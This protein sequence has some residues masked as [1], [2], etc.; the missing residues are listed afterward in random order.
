MY[1]KNIL[2]AIQI[3]IDN[4]ISKAGFDKTVQGII[5]KCVDEKNG[6]YVVIYQ[7]SSFYAYSNDTSQT[8]SA[9]TPVYVHIPKN[10]FTKTKTIIGSVNK[11]GSDYINKVDSI[12]KYDII[13]N[14]VLT[15]DEEQGVCSYLPSGDILILYNKDAESSL[16]DIDA[17]AANTYINQANYLVF[18]GK[19]RTNLEKEQKY[20][21]VYG[22]GFDLIF[23]DNMT[24]ESVKRTYLVSVN[25]MTGNPYEYTKA[26]NQK[27]VFNIDGAN[28]IEI[29]KIY[30]FCYDFP[31]SS[32]E[33]KPDD[34]FVSDITLEAAA[35][36]TNDELEGNKLT[37]KTPQGVYFDDTDNDNSQRS[38]NTEVRIENNLVNENS[39][40]LKYYW[41]KENYL[42]NTASLKYQRYGGIGWECLNDYN[43]IEQDNGT[44][45]KLSWIANKSKYFVSKGNVSS[46]TTEYKCVVIYN[47]TIVLT[48]QITIYNYSS[49]Y[50]IS[51][52]SDSGVNFSYDNGHPTLTCVV[53]TPGDYIYSWGLIDT[54][55]TYSDIQQTTQD[56]TTYHTYLNRYNELQTGLRNGTI[57]LTTEIQQELIQLRNSLENYNKTIMRVEDNVIYNLKLNMISNF[58]TFVCS[59]YRETTGGDVVYLGKGKIK[60]TNDLNT[61]DNSYT[62][63]INHGNQIFKYD[64]DGKSPASKFLENP[65][66]I[67]PFSFTLYDEKG[68]EINNDAID[69]KNV[70]WTV[71]TNNTMINVSA[72]HGNPTSIDEINQTKTYTEYKELFFEIPS[73]YNSNNIRNTVQLEIKYKNKIVRGNAEPV[74]LKEG[75]AGSNGTGLVCR[76]IPNLASG[77]ALAT[78]PIVTHNT[79]LP[80]SSSNP[81]LNYEPAN[82]NVWFKAQLFKDGEEIFNGPV[83]ANSSEGRTVN[84]RWEMLTNKYDKTHTDASSFNVNATTGVFSYND[85]SSSEDIIKNN[86][87]NIV[88]CTLTYDDVEYIATM[89]IILV[90]TT[91]G[92]RLDVVKDSGFRYVMYSSD[93]R[94]PIYSSA[95]PFALKV[96]ET[97][98]GVERDVSIATTT[99]AAVNYTWFI[100]GSIWNGS[101][102]EVDNNLVEKTYLSSTLKRNENS[103][104]PI[105]IYNGLTVN[106]GLRC[107]IT[108]SGTKLAEI[109]LPIHFYLNRYGNAALNGWDGNHI[110]INE[111]GGFILAPQIGAGKKENDNSYTGIFM[112]EV[113]EAGESESQTGLFGYNHGQK[114]IVLDT[115]DGSARFGAS[116]QGQ[117]VIDPGADTAKL[118]SDDYQV[119]YISPSDMIPAQ[120]NYLS[121]YSYWRRSGLDNYT[122]LK[123]LE[124]Y[125]EG[126]YYQ[127]NFYED[128]NYSILITPSVNQKYYDKL[129]KECYKYTSDNEY[130]ELTNYYKNGDI[131]KGTDYVWAGGDGL[132][133]D[134]NDP[135]IRFGSGKFRVDSDGQ[136]YATGFVNVVE[137]ENGDYNIPGMKNFQLEYPVEDVQFETN[138]KYYPTE[139]ITRTISCKCLYKE[140]I[141]DDYIVNLIDGQGNVITHDT[142]HNT[143]TDGIS[144]SITKGQ[145]GTAAIAFSVDSSKKVQNV[146]NDYLFRFVYTPT[147]DTIDKI[148]G[149]NLIIRGTSISVNGSYASLQALLDDVDDGVITP[150]E[151][152][153]YVI[154]GDL[155]VYTNAGSGGGTLAADWEDVGRFTGESAKQCVIS[156]TSEAF[157]SNDGGTTYTPNSITITPYFQNVNYSSWAYSTD[158]GANFIAMPNPLPTGIS[159]DVASKALTISRNCE[160]F[161]NSTILV[162]KCIT[163]G[164]VDNKVVYDTRT[165]MKVKDGVN[166]YSIWTTTTAPSTTTVED[167]TTYTFL[168]ANLIGPSGRAPAVG[169][170]VIRSNRYQYTISEVT[171]TT[172]KAT[173]QEDLKGHNSATIN[174]YGRFESAPNKPYNESVTYTFTTHTLSSIPTGWSQTV[175]AIDGNKKLYVSSAVAYGNENLTTIEANDWSTPTAM[176]ENGS[177]G[178]S[179]TFVTCGNEAQTFICD[180]SGAATEDTLITIPFGG[181]IGNNRAACTVTYSTLPANMIFKSNVAATTESDGSLVFSI[182]NGV[183]VAGDSGIIDLT[184]TCNNKTFVKKFS[185]AKSLTGKSG[186][187]SAIVNLYKRGTNPSSFSPPY[188]TSVN[189]SFANGSLSSPPDPGTGWTQT[190]PEGTD[191]LYITFALAAGTGSSDGIDP[192]EWSTPTRLVQNGINGEDGGNTANVMLYQ[193]NTSIPS[194]PSE[195]VTYN[196]AD[197]TIDEP[198]RVLGN[199]S[200]TIPNGS[201]PLYVTSAIAFGNGASVRIVSTKWSTPTILVE[202]GL[203]GKSIIVDTTLSQYQISDSGTIIPTGDWLTS[204]P[205]TP[206][207]PEGK[208]LWTR[209]ITAY[210]LEGTGISAG[211]S[212]S[213]SVTYL[214]SSGSQSLSIISITPL[215]YLKTTNGAPQA[216]TAHIT[217][218]S[219]IPNQWTTVVPKYDT[220]A[221]Y[222]TCSEILY[223][224]NTYGTNGYIWTNVAANMSANAAFT[225]AKETKEVVEI[226]D[227]RIEQTEEQIE[228]LSGK[229]VPL[230]NTI[231]SPESITL[232]DPDP[233]PGTLHK[234]SIYG[235]MSLFY[236]NSIGDIYGYPSVPGDNLT[237]GNITPNQLV[238]Y[239][240]SKIYPSSNT[241]TAAPIL[242]VNNTEYNI[243]IDF[244]NYL[245]SE[246]YDEFVCEEERSYIIRRVG[247]D[248]QGNKYKLAVELIEERQH[249]P[250]KVEGE[251]TIVLKSFSNMTYI[252]EYL[253][254]N[255]YTDTFTTNWD[256]ISRINMSPEQIEISSSKINMNGWISANKNFWIDEEGNMGARNGTFTGN[257]Y[258]PDGGRVIGGDGLLTNLQFASYGIIN[259]WDPLGFGGDDSGNTLYKDVVVDYFL[260]KGFTPTQAYL[261]LYTSRVMTSYNGGGYN[262]DTTGAPQQLK[263][264]HGNTNSTYQIFWENGSSYFYRGD[265]SVSTEI[266][267]AFGIE[268]YT[269]YISTVGAVDK[270]TTEINLKDELPKQ[271]GNYNFIIRTALSKPSSPIGQAA[272]E[273][274]GMGRAF[275]NIIGYMSIEKSE[276]ES[277]E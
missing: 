92:Y 166:G 100:S 19:F 103:Y 114:T 91:S 70:S 189:Y 216:P 24:G 87:A 255:I 5:S 164:T 268:S 16:I 173:A 240:D 108:R 60:I 53:N 34:I 152:D 260:P 142:A 233:Y 131:I 236:P 275:L 83:T 249:V 162:F 220:G 101:S 172:V 184:F 81:T 248:E 212:E 71:P 102:W 230:S 15:L 25:N 221:T 219:T 132:E 199:W 202:N 208:Y 145:D 110:E 115:K 157:K 14:S 116:D 188:S 167:V 89:P 227:T 191:P 171:S 52:E 185:W 4:A 20:K 242:L 252:A 111:D 125:I 129:A 169:E 104:G 270:K 176:A 79:S 28:F 1:E 2:E 45:T 228:A 193:R 76:I 126:Y 40:M 267:K 133:I 122:L 205:E 23:A 119:G 42:I 56:N 97:V 256:L 206:K 68:N 201:D 105:D 239:R 50:N 234:L 245:S 69:A 30:L 263:L 107:V 22:L 265:L 12:D 7:D 243:D 160:L 36:L 128:R 246:I 210:K 67:Y 61:G 180:A 120:T 135:H 82:T 264:Y 244:L 253:I 54:A 148:F 238:P 140:E 154:N 266:K 32:S 121:G 251:T 124:D 58:A 272:V 66:E 258:L 62:L 26:S 95:N 84:V 226:Y 49:E 8:Y 64:G 144:I 181:Y 254:D 57:Y 217:S 27:V 214:G 33:E 55:G 229:V 165:I 113:R 11:L 88:K 94:T 150:S 161:N 106:N 187:N 151:G 168:I 21:G 10:D 215:Y 77:N 3:L 41:F 177:D 47:D 155:Y 186:I 73:V 222:Y 72:V 235:E 153:A 141:T 225:I 175:P 223:N 274:T 9:G 250:I 93:G 156:A 269:P 182:A 158:G 96:Y 149:A 112:G 190:I 178:E 257:V 143:D 136:V 183:V 17:T 6:K 271:S 63:V 18:G 130:Q 261:T 13:G 31:N 134:L 37:L 247:I 203:D 48:K 139:T 259:G 262:V 74:F 109:L 218:D 207:D 231:I 204:R 65:Q 38:I 80:I 273:S 200:Q 237:C 170:I 90:K 123:S 198:E 78:Y 35:A 179:P 51:I 137:L 192:D 213:Y 195:T 138:V 43:I 211:S 118:Y 163:D 99:A 44:P 117:I 276:E 75:E 209:T 29:D 46:K 197:G 86:P 232:T 59:V 146:I 159:M 196:F 98:E 127:G 277:N 174:L 147:G 39:D 224:D 241:Y 85:L 194:T